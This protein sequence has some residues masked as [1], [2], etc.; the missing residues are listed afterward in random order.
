[1]KKIS[2][3]LFLITLLIASS[4]LSVAVMEGKKE[5]ENG[6]ESVEKDNVQEASKKAQE[7]A[8]TS[9]ASYAIPVSNKTLLKEEGSD[10]DEESVAGESDSSKD[11]DSE[12]E[13]LFDVGVLD[14]KIEEAKEELGNV[15]SSN[16]TVNLRDIQDDLLLSSYNLERYQQKY[17][18]LEKLVS[19]ASSD[20]DLSVQQK[21]E[22][23]IE[24]TSDLVSQLEDI[25]KSSSQNDITRNQ[26][27]P[28]KH[29]FKEL[30]LSNTKSKFEEEG[31]FHA[32]RNDPEAV[33]VKTNE[34]V[35]K[36][37]ND[38]RT[39]FPGS[40]RLQLL[41]TTTLLGL[42]TI[43]S[44]LDYKPLMNYVNSKLPVLTPGDSVFFH[45]YVHLD[46]VKERNQ[47]LSKY[48]RR[49]VDQDNQDWV[50]I[51]GTH[52]N[53]SA[54]K[55]TDP[56]KGGNSAHHDQGSLSQVIS[57]TGTH[58]NESAI[59]ITG[60]FEGGNS[61]HHNQ[62]SLRS[63]IPMTESGS[64]EPV[65]QIKSRFQGGNSAHHDQE[66]PSNFISI[67]SHGAYPLT[68]TD[69]D[70]LAFLETLDE[71]GKL[72]QKGDNNSSQPEEK[73]PKEV[74]E[75]LKRVA[76]DSSVSE[77]GGPIEEK[78]PEASSNETV[79]KEQAQGHQE[80]KLES[81]EWNIGHFLP[82][83]VI[84][85][86]LWNTIKKWWNKDDALERPTRYNRTSSSRINPPGSPRYDSDSDS[87][88]E[89]SV[90]SPRFNQTAND[91][92]TGNPVSLPGDGSIVLSNSTDNLSNESP[93]GSSSSLTE[94]QAVIP[95]HELSRT[96]SGTPSVNDPNELIGL[97]HTAP[98]T[99]LPEQDS[100]KNS[101]AP[102]TTLKGRILR[103]AKFFSPADYET[104]QQPPLE[105]RRSN[106]IKRPVNSFTP[107]QYQK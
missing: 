30:I 53:N 83:S 98:Y 58:Y 100:N 11:T 5:G 12:A 49:P 95:T 88:R 87:D 43:F 39:H 104:Q 23:L 42:V 73:L 25:V 44:Q 51:A 102:K 79:F 92:G 103:Q 71:K 64:D 77:N 63:F 27:E 54:I 10:H 3:L 70:V 86:F 1:M 62:A 29:L 89:D 101:N 15:S 34:Q 19:S 6:G 90:D 33:P 81:G 82:A 26:E 76:N 106:R 7:K 13:D 93:R 38:T 57:R 32:N 17:N 67:T 84:A 66:S 107:S 97:I 96:P 75:E 48:I 65:I 8:L 28:S 18:N 46:G 105:T 2:L 24:V 78:H 16:V 36:N 14:T 72:S 20:L 99:P 94:S 52:D 69:Y 55:I 80:K 59:E 68:T 4:R 91:V 22:Q 41:R 85:A 60:S 74:L 40:K 50:S 37:K 21:L 56:F 9:H 47:V 31:E 35:N 45:P 61:A